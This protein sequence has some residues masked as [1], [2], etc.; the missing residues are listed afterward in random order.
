[1]PVDHS[2]FIHRYIPVV[3]D[4]AAR[5]AKRRRRIVGAALAS[6]GY[7]GLMAGTAHFLDIDGKTMMLAG[8]IFI[9]AALLAFAT[10]QVLARHRR[11]EKERQL[12]R[13]VMEG[14]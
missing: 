7:I 9:G 6:V 10:Q 1:M 13:E 3:E 8:G 14:S 11:H 2:E 4:T 5:T 12:I